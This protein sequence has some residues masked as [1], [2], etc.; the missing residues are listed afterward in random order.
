[1]AA[2][3]GHIST[4]YNYSILLYKGDGVEQDM[5]EVAKYIKIAAVEDDCEIFK[6]GIMLY[7]GEG[8]ELNKNEAAGYFKM[9]TDKGHLAYAI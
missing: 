5:N 3:K 4:M 7:R 8:V 1:M 9:S 2:D 6:Y